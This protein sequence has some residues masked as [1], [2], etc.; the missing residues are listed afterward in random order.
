MGYQNVD[1]E[2]HQNCDQLWEPLVFPFSPSKFDIDVF[3]FD[4]T[5]GIQSFPQGAY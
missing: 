4:V 1:V 2:T 5:E 3:A